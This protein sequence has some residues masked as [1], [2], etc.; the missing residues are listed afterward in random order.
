MVMGCGGVQGI[1]GGHDVVAIDADRF[2]WIGQSL[3]CQYRFDKET[4]G[5]YDE[6]QGSV[7]AT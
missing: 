5:G 6:R 1:K 2:R 3:Q 4:S 7:S